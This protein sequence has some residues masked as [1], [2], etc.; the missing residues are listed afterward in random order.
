[1][2][3]KPAALGF[4]GKFLQGYEV[5]NQARKQKWKT[6]AEGQVKPEFDLSPGI[7]SCVDPGGLVKVHSVV[8]G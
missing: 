6:T 1:M 8:V 3:Y 5:E 2:F 7:G 4:F